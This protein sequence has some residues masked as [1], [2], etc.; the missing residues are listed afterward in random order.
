VWQE[1]QLHAEGCVRGLQ[2][3]MRKLYYIFIWEEGDMKTE[4]VLELEN[5]MEKFIDS[6]VRCDDGSFYVD[7]ETHIFMARAAAAVYDAMTSASM[8]EKQAAEEAEKE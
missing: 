7:E 8:L 5:Q 6:G 4:L 1:K 3:G 2:K